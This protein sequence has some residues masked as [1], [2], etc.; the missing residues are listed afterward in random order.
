MLNLYLFLGSSQ[1]VA[2]VRLLRSFRRTAARCRIRFG[3]R[4]SFFRRLTLNS[5]PSTLNLITLPVAREYEAQLKA[6]KEKKVR[7][8]LPAVLAAVLSA[9]MSNIK[10]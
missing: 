3:P 9:Q 6:G 10:I 1:Q 2:T 7:E 5:Q 8:A 4:N